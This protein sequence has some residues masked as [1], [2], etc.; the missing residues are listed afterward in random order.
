MNIEKWKKSDRKAIMAE[1]SNDREL[2]ENIVKQYK[3]QNHLDFTG[4]LVWKYEDIITEIKRQYSN[5]EIYSGNYWL[6]NASDSCSVYFLMEELTLAFDYFLHTQGELEETE[7]NYYRQRHKR[8]I[9]IPKEL[10]TSII[11]HNRCSAKISQELLMKDIAILERLEIGVWK[12]DELKTECLYSD[13]FRER[14]KKQ[15]YT[16]KHPVKRR[17]EH[18]LDLDFKRFNK[19]SYKEFYD[20]VFAVYYMDRHGIEINGESQRLGILD[21]MKK[22]RIQITS[23]YK[24]HTTVIDDAL[25]MNMF[26]NAVV[27]NIGFDEI[28]EIERVVR[29]T[30]NLY[31]AVFNYVARFMMDVNMEKGRKLFELENLTDRIHKATEVVDGVKHNEK[32]SHYEGS[33]WSLVYLRYRSFMEKCRKADSVKSLEFALNLGEPQNICFFDK[34]K[35][36]SY[37]YACVKTDKITDYILQNPAALAVLVDEKCNPEWILKNIPRIQKFV[38]LVFRFNTLFGREDCAVTVLIA[39]YQVIFELEKNRYKYENSYKNYKGNKTVSI[40]AKLDTSDKRSAE[41][42]AFDYVLMAMVKR[43]FHYNEWNLALYDARVDMEIRFVRMIDKIMGL[44]SLLDIE[45]IVEGMYVEFAF[46]G[47]G[48]TLDIKEQREREFLEITGYKLDIQDFGLIRDFQE[49][50]Y[51]RWFVNDMEKIIQLN[52]YY[53]RESVFHLNQR[54]ALLELQQNIKDKTITLY[55]TK[56]LRIGNA[57]N[58]FL[59]A[60]ELELPWFAAGFVK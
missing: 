37:R 17:I 46:P 31:T 27:R 53:N 3:A 57:R 6:E 26:K 24:R 49:D 43:W 36:D 40:L 45:T 39:M 1:G 28:C 15:L 29:K 9:Q 48:F 25:Y 7:Q 11:F 44:D 21:T 32:K 35:E 56:Y 60:L 59:R 4:T 55:H 20:L 5:R 12:P 30:N 14:M 23:D 41:T 16:G 54:Y 51:F 38:E 34:Y 13:D 2:A 22:P 58:L 18:I 19:E 52:E 50:G 33:V 47:T 8:E 10:E 42:E